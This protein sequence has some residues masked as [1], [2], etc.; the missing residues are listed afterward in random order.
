M[1]QKKLTPL[2][3]LQMQKNGLQKKSDELAATIENRAM[4]LKLHFVPLLRDSLME[5]AV[6]KMPS[7]LRMLAGNFLQKEKKSETRNL[8]ARRVTQGIVIGLAGI[9]PFFLKGK[10]GAF[11]SILLKQLVKLI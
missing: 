4:Y 11:L 10:K 7:P 2:E 1:K 8:P 6:S 9:A 3:I 5:S